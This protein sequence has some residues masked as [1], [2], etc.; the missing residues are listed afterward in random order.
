MN[1]EVF[2][3]Y[4]AR[5][6]WIGTAP[7]S[8]V[9][10]AGH[11]HQTVHCWLVRRGEDGKARVLFQL[12]SESKDTNPGLC[13]ITAAGHLTAGESPRE[14]VRELEEELGLAVGFDELIPYGVVR[15]D[16]SGVVR[17][18]RFV[19][20][21]VSHV[22]GYVTDRQPGQFRLQ[23][24]EVAG[25]Y[26]APAGELIALMEGGMVEARAN[27]IRLREGLM[28]PEFMAVRASSFVPR[29]PAYYAGVFRFLEKL[30][31]GS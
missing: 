20:R 24:A 27:G 15:E 18:K 3:I 7:R 12:R 30:A 6:T 11:W 2:D 10:A 16:A 19:D 1:E 8:E 31:L 14:A 26:E 29:D 4:D 21:E 13:D 23:E 17:G 5:G 9:H 22:F 25:L 28:E